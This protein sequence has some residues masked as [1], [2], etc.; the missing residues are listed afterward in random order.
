M[1]TVISIFRSTMSPAGMAFEKKAY[2][3]P[4]AF[5]DL[6]FVRM[7]LASVEQG[8]CSNGFGWHFLQTQ[9]PSSGEFHG[10]HC[11]VNLTSRERFLHGLFLDLL[12]GGFAFLSPDTVIAVNRS[13]TK[14]SAVLRFPS[15][16]V[17]KRLLLGG[18]KL[19]P[20]AHGNY[21]IAGPLNDSLMGVLDLSSDKI[22]F[23]AN[24]ARRLTPMIRWSF[25]REGAAKS[26]YS[27]SL[28]IKSRPMLLSR[29]LRS[30]VS[31][32]RP[33]RPT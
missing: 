30:A 12:K 20:P 24:M 10:F 33:F 3:S 18:E 14:N 1:S 2:F 8:P 15:G 13:D 6:A 7:M 23:A 19:S 21:A 16:E 27:T 5:Y 22:V 11:Q 32:Q 9:K 17:T 31:A 28:R 29:C 26:D 4:G 25:S